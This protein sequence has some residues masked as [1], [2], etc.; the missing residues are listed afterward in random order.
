MFKDGVDSYV[1]LEK[2][3]EF[4]DKFIRGELFD[5]EEK[6]KYS[7]DFFCKGFLSDEVLEIEREWLGDFKYDLR[8]SFEILGVDVG[9]L[10]VK[11]MLGVGWGLGKLIGLSYE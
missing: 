7:V 3:V 2:K 1:V 11:L 6:E 10:E 9:M 8:E 4:Y 5:E